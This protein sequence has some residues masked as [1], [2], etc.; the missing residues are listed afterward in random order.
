MGA[1][2]IILIILLSVDLLLVAN[3]HGKPRENYNVWTVIFSTAL[4]IGLLLWG[5]FFK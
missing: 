3:K 5:G 2:Q 1:P 4:F